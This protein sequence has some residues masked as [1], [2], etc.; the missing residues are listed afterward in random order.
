MEK[1]GKLILVPWD[2]SPMAEYALVHGI[3]IARNVDNEIE[4]LHIVKSGTKAQDKEK[5]AVRLEEVASRTEKEYGIRPR[6]LIR[7]GSIFSEISDYATDKGANLV[8]MGT[9]GIKGIQKITGS[10]ALRVIVGSKV[11]YLVIQ[12]KPR[13]M[14][15]YHN[16]VFPI[17]FRVE[18]KEKLYMAIY[19]GKYFE[20]K[21]HILKEAVTDRSLLKKINVNLNFAMKFLLQNNI[22]Y[23]LHEAKKDL[24]FAKETVRFA[25]EINAD[26][27]MVMTTKNITIGDYLFG[28]TEQQIIAN[29][30]KI[31]VLCVNPKANFAKVA[32]YMYG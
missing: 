12:D 5:A 13:D 4:I 9:H 21:V 17:D 1:D 7:E 16:V 11:P 3:K 19:M 27:I 2:F 6:T 30:H 8:I 25:E 10:Y 28:A 26:L 15:K 31:P 20:S 14:E 32:Q 18:N 23:E 29:P 22:D 24:T